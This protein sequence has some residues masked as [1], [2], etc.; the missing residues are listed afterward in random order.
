[1]VTE[2]VRRKTVS[3]PP[4]H[5]KSAD[6]KNR[7]TGA[8]GVVKAHR[9]SPTDLITDKTALSYKKE[10]NNRINIKIH[11]QLDPGPKQSIAGICVRAI[12]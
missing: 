3:S 7:P 9:Q 4:K 8:S 12:E 2:L 11:R 5:N 1:M 10:H 6:S